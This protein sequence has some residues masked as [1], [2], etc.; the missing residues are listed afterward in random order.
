MDR[1]PFRER[2]LLITEPPAWPGALLSGVPFDEFLVPAEAVPRRAFHGVVI[3]RDQAEIERE[4]QLVLVGI[5][6]RPG[7][8]PFHGDAALDRPGQHHDMRAYI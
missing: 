1:S 3:H 4:A 5:L 6:D 2:K 7:V 8:I